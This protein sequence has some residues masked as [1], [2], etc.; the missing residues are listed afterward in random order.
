MLLQHARR[1]ARLVDGELV[2]LEEQDRSRWDTGAIDRGLALLDRPAA[3]R[4]ALPHPGR[5][6]RRARDR[7]RRGRD[8]LAADRDVVRRAAGR[9]HPSPVVE[10]NRAIAVGMSDG[11]LAGLAEL[12]D[13]RR[14]ARRPAPRARGARRAAGAG[15]PH[16]R[17]P[18]RA[19]P[20][21]R[22]RPVGPGAPPAATAAGP[23]RRRPGIV[24]GRRPR[25]LPPPSGHSASR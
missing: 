22:A 4:G 6:G 1:H 13:G 18:G 24:D 21:D 2:T 23:P 19:R 16:R 10:L 8:R 20:G 25:A 17:G 5:A 11:P 9:V 7:A 3:G 12:D 14:P 15:R